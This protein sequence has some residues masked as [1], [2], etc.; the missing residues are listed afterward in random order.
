ML[1]TG[2]EET[3]GL[4]SELVEDGA[5]SEANAG[6][7]CTVS[8]VALK[9]AALASDLEATTFDEGAEAFTLENRLPE[10]SDVPDVDGDAEE[11]G[12]GDDIICLKMVE[13][14]DD[15]PVLLAWTVAWKAD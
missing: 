5:A 1:E 4:E 3:E 12:V 8:F 2:V 15:E 13:V 6:F 7:D 11:P 9:D 14:A 10:S